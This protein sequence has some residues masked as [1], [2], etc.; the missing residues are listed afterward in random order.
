M[1]ARVHARPLNST[2]PPRDGAAGNPRFGWLGF[3]LVGT[4]EDNLLAICEA[5]S[6][7]GLM[8][9]YKR[10]QVNPTDLA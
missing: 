7:D 5:S 10:Y 4:S 2:L 6:I 8:R 1:Y 3:R 9:P